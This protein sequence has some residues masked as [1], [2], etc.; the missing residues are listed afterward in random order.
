[1]TVDRT[2]KPNRF[3][4]VLIGVLVL[5]VIVGAVIGISHHQ[6]SQAIEIVLPTEPELEG[7]IEI[8][9][10]VAN[11]GIYPFSTNDSLDSLL[12]AAGGITAGADDDSLKLTVPYN[13]ESDRPQKIN[14]NRAEIWLLEALPGIGETRARAI[15]DYRE[16]HGLFKQT[17]ELMNVE[18]IGQSLYENIKDLISVSD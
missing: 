5:V 13:D 11:P 4:A 14:I 12:Q 1:M 18:G 17:S 3:W 7:N 2:G 8:A 9:G 10:A 15:I 16:L 6:P